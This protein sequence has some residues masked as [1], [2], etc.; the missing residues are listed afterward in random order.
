MCLIPIPLIS[1]RRSY[2]SHVTVL[3]KLDYSTVGIGNGIYLKV[4]RKQETFGGLAQL[5]ESARSKM[6]LLEVAP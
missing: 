2:E 4:F 6:E 5:W 3:S 1:V